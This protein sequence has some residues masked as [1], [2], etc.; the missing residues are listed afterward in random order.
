MAILT[1]PIR[2]FVIINS[3]MFPLLLIVIA[4]LLH[5]YYNPVKSVIDKITEIED[6]IINN[7]HIGVKVIS[8]YFTI[9]KNT[10]TSDSLLDFLKER[11]Q[12]TLLDQIFD[13]INHTQ[14]LATT[15]YKW[16]ITDGTEIFNTF[17]NLYHDISIT[18]PLQLSKLNI[19]RIV[20]RIVV[21]IKS[22]VISITTN[23]DVS[24]SDN[25]KDKI[26]SSI[27]QFKSRNYT[28]GYILTHHELGYSK[29]QF[30]TLGKQM[31]ENADGD[32]YCA[33][34]NTGTVVADPAPAPATTPAPAPATTPATTPAT[35]PAPATTPA[36]E[37]NYIVKNDD[38]DKLYKDYYINKNQRLDSIKR[39]K[40]KYRKQVR[41]SIPN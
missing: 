33:D 12:N 28:I 20:D 13:F 22:N 19:D 34:D 3:V 5:R 14:E 10:F 11:I 31:L 36:T 18:S 40:E 25:V 9:I 4:Y 29:T 30:C 23:D 39:Q 8:E 32:T 16:A 21:M 17:S 7:L 41:F 15:H 35:A 26:I 6:I 37:E 38:Q 27:S 1:H 24:I 2:V